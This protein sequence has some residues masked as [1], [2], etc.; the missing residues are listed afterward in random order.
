MGED[1]GDG[2]G[3]WRWGRTVEMGEDCGDGTYSI[4]F[5]PLTIGRHQLCIAIHGHHILNNQQAAE[6][7][8]TYFSPK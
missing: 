4:S 2:G 3:L 8:D 5:T 6:H 1:C 7:I